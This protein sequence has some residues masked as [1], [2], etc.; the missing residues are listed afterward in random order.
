LKN[1]ADFSPDKMTGV[2]NDIPLLLPL[3][4]YYY[5]P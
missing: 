3:K 5:L 1:E 4:F 2:R